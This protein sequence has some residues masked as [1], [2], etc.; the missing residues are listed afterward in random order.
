MVIHSILFA[1]M[2]FLASW[3]QKLDFLGSCLEIVFAKASNFGGTLEQQQTSTKTLWEF[4][5]LMWR[6]LVIFIS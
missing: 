3:A 6:F 1:C 4:L 2:I 5:P